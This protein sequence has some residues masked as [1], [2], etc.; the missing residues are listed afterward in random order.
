MAP[1]ILTR[2]ELQALTLYANGLSTDEVAQRL[3]VHHTISQDWLRVAARKLGAANRVHA[4]A[5]AVELGIIR[6]LRG[7]MRQQL[8][9]RHRVKEPPQGRDEQDRDQT[10][11]QP[12]LFASAAHEDAQTS[13]EETT[14]AP[15]SPD[16]V[17]ATK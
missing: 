11:L 5:I 12:D 9:V 7:P 15:D 8:D 2:D 4:V 3:H 14:T 13:A 17:T 1:R 6:T 10:R 16:S